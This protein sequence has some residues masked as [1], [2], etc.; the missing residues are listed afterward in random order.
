MSL[1]GPPKQKETQSERELA[2][3][4]SERYQRW[5]D[6]SKPLENKNIQRVKSMGS[7]VERARTAGAATT[8]LSRELGPTMPGS[9]L[10]EIAAREGVRT[11]GGGKALAQSDYTTKSRWDKGRSGLVGLGQ[12][13]ENTGISGLSRQA[14]VEQTRQIA[15]MEADSIRDAG[16]SDAAGIGIGYGLYRMGNNKT[17]SFDPRSPM[18]ASDYD[19]ERLV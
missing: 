11:S 3:V 19:P 17:L 18:S 7:P 5:K 12:E 9:G 16:I 4:T 15:K 14:A 13:I 1:D 2:R 8:S 10:R 6:V